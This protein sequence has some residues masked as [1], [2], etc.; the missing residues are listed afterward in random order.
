MFTIV[1]ELEE[2]GFMATL[3]EDQ[4]QYYKFMHMRQEMT[5]KNRKFIHKCISCDRYSHNVINCPR[6]HFIRRDIKKLAAQYKHL[7]HYRE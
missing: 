4:R 6:I 3:G 1:Y 7:K 2:D 5:D